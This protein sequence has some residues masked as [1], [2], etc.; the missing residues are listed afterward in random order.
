M[1]P[2]SKASLLAAA[3]ALIATAALAG[4]NIAGY[5][6]RDDTM[7]LIGRNFYIGIGRVVSGRNPY[8]PDTVTSAETL[9]KLV[10]D[11]PTLFPPGSDVEQSKMNPAI[12]TASDRD[13]LIA[14][15]Q[16]AAT[17][18]VPAVKDG[19]MNK[20]AMADAYKAVADAC[21]ACHK[22]YRNE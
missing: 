10:A 14:H 9:T 16:Q 7:K 12:L 8:G 20:Q 22:K 17:G 3:A 19:A 21:N 18:L 2:I 11:L 4:D 6:K 13:E 5:Q 1:R 15:V